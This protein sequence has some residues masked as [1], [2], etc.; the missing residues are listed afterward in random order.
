MFSDFTCM[1][2]FKPGQM[3]D[4]KSFFWVMYGI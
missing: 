1:S 3:E 2:A 4:S